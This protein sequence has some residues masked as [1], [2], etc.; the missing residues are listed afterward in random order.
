ML[1]KVRH[2]MSFNALK[3][4]YH[5]MFES[6]LNYLLLV[7]AQNANSIKRLLVLQKKFLRIMYLLKRN[8]QRSSLSIELN[9]LK[10]Q[11]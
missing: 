6:H 2:I 10:H 4:I 5:A 9:V 3:A 7:W 11:K 8:A 1:S